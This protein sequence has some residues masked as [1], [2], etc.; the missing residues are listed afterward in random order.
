MFLWSTDSTW[1]KNKIETQMCKILC[2]DEGLEGASL[3]TSVLVPFLRGTDS[4]SRDVPR[5]K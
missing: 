5:K 3:F 2:L 1:I 4:T